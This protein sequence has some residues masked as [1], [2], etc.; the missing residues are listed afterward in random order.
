[1]IEQNLINSSA[2]S[3]FIKRIC[4]VAGY[5]RG[6]RST[7]NRSNLTEFLGFREVEGLTDKWVGVIRRFITDYLDFVN[8][9][10]DK[11]KTIEYLKR[12]K[13]SYSTTTYC[14][15]IYQI[16]KFLTYLDVDWAK[17][18]KPP[19]KPVYT[20]K[21]ITLDDIKNTLSYYEG[22]RFFKQIKA[23]IPL[24]ST[25]G[26]RAEEMYQLVPEDIDLENRTIHINHDPYNGQSTKT[27]IGRVSFFNQE[28]QEAIMEYI[29]FFDNGSNLTCL[30]N[31]SHIS[32]IFKD[33]PI[34]VKDLRKFF[35][36]ECDRRGGPTSIKKILMGGP[37]H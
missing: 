14:K 36:Q 37:P 32:R 10:I 9:N 1:M 30:F 26:M 5:H 25:S 22:H 18:I 8:W 16:R 3:A 27:R 13:N 29:E 4:G 33:A 34:L 24:G 11:D 28:A 31:Q 15:K 35:S 7:V 2:D 12:I 21:R 6:L 23:I 19:I 17:D 20:V